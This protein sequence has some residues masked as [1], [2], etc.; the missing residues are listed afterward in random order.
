ME[1]DTPRVFGKRNYKNKAV[2][3]AAVLVFG[4]GIG[5]IAY[6]ADIGG[7][8]ETI[9]I[10][11]HGKETE[12][13]FDAE[14]GSYSL[15]YTDENGEKHNVSGG[16][17]AL[18]GMFRKERP[19]TKEELMAELNAPDVDYRED[20]KVIVYFLDQ[21]VDITD[22]FKDDICRLQLDDNGKPLFMTVKYGE[23]FA[24]SPNGYPDYD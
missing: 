8:R 17:V 24:A 18:G 16:G 20:G 15:E 3:L 11:I 13:D 19:A 10:W 4:L 9:S 14:N 22:R 5:S 7:I 6:A 21:A 1:T 2:V 12:A 23:G